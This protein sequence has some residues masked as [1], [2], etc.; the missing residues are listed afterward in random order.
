MAP[1]LPGLYRGHLPK[2]ERT[3]VRDADSRRRVQWPSYTVNDGNLQSKSRPGGER[4]WVACA[5]HTTR[6]ASDDTEMDLGGRL[7]TRTP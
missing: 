1:T 7:K 3:A 4:R 2:R 6:L 5:M